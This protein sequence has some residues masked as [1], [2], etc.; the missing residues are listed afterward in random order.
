VIDTTQH[1]Q[2][3]ILVHNSLSVSQTRV[4]SVRI[5]AT[6]KVKIIDNRTNEPVPMQVVEDE[7]TDDVYTVYFLASTPP[8]GYSTFT[9][10]NTGERI[11]QDPKYLAKVTRISEEELTSHHLTTDDLSLLMDSRGMLR[12]CVC[13]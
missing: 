4:T 5:K 13:E 6:R 7:L 2:V 1:S 11:A 12:T 8:M 10:I 3:T 9:L